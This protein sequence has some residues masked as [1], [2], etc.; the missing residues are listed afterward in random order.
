VNPFE[1][2]G[3]ILVIW[4]V[5]VAALGITREGFPGKAEKLVGLI[6]FVLVVVAIGSA[7]YTGATEKR[8]GGSERKPSSA[9]LHPSV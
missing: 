2:C 1:V 9:L 5:L 3:S 8:A 4:A 7:I 6:S